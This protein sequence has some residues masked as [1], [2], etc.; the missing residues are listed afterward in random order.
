MQ[1]EV[2]LEVQVLYPDSTLAI[3]DAPGASSAPLWNNGDHHSQWGS[4]RPEEFN[5]SVDD[6]GG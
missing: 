3:G 6:D 1:K 5:L 2:R 4:Q